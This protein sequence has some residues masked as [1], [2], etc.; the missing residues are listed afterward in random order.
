[1]KIDKSRD[2]CGQCHTKRNCEY[3]QCEGPH[4]CGDIDKHEVEKKQLLD[5]SQNVKTRN[6][7]L[8]KLKQ[9]LHSKEEISRETCQTFFSQVVSYL[10]NTDA[11]KYYPVGAYGLRALNMR[12]IQP[13]MAILEKHYRG[14]VPRKLEEESAG[15]QAI[16]AGTNAEVATKLKDPV[17]NFMEK[18]GVVFPS[19]PPRNPA[20]TNI[21]PLEP[22]SRNYPTYSYAR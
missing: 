19:F 7:G 16:I 5:A 14:K 22:H 3:G 18:R 17:R 6:R 21:L 10:V 2:Q 4:I 20:H 13:D 1:L 15:F 11:D 9:S 12:A 8:E